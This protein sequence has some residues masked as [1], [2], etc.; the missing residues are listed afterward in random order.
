[1]FVAVIFVISEGASQFLSDELGKVAGLLAAGVVMF[2]LAPL[3]RFA[4]RVASAAM[5]NTQ[6]NVYERRLTFQYRLETQFLL[7]KSVGLVVSC[8]LTRN[9]KPFGKSPVYLL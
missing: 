3:Q 4:E 2:F 8:S 1:M 9:S 6:N 7:I 5:P